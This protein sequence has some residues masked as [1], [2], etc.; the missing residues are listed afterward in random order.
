MFVFLL[1]LLLVS[2]FLFVF[3]MF[4]HFILGLDLGFPRYGWCTFFSLF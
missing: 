1:L 2:I 3:L 4:L